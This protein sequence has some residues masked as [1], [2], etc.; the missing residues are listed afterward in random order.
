MK[1]AN[2]TVSAPA[3]RPRPYPPGM[4]PVPDAAGGTVTPE[5]LTR[6]PGAA[7][8]LA[9]HHRQSG[10]PWAWAAATAGA[11]FVAHQMPG[12]EAQLIAVAASAV[13][14][15]TAAAVNM[16]R[17]KRSGRV[18][19]VMAQIV[20]AD[21]VWTL[22]AALAGPASG[23]RFPPLL[24]AL[25]A[26]A[27]VSAWKWRKAAG[28]TV[29]AAPALPRPLVTPSQDPRLALFMARICK[30]GSPLHNARIDFALIDGGFLAD[31]ILDPDAP[32]T[33]D[34]VTRLALPIAKAFD[35]PLDQV[36]VED[37]PGRRSAGRARITVL[38][39]DAAMIEPEW[40]DGK[41][42]YDPE[43]GTVIIGRYMDGTPERWL[44][45]Q[46]GSGAVGGVDAGQQGYG[47]TT[48]A[49]VVMTESAKARL[50]TLCGPAHAC[51]RCRM[52]RFVCVW[53][54]DPTRKPFVQ[55]KGRADL[56]AWGPR[57][58]ILMTLWAV[59]A[60]KARTTVDTG[61]TDHRGRV[62]EGKGWYDPNPDMP[63][64]QLTVDEWP[65]IVTDPEGENATAA[66]SKLISL[67]RKYGVAVNLITLLPDL[68][69]MG[70]RDIRELLL[71]YNVL[72]H[73]SDSLSS[74]TL[75]IQGNPA[76]LPVNVPGLNFMAGVDGR[77][78]VVARVK[79]LREVLKPGETGVD[80]RDLWDRIALDPVDLESS[81]M[82]VLRPL[83][84]TG[85]G[86]VLKDED[87]T[88]GMWNAALVAA[89]FATA[90]PVSPTTAQAVKALGEIAAPQGGAV[91]LKEASA[92]RRAIEAAALDGRTAD[93]FDVIRGTEMS[94]LAGRNAANALVAVGDAV[95][96]GDGK[97]TVPSR[98]DAR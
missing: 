19:R 48:T 94:V 21:A 87:I 72:C 30:P 45:H 97:Y 53:A 75:G 49:L 22:T 63:L 78:A 79:G 15:A 12:V 40:W 47:K 34:D 24:I 81:M 67:G 65:Q 51:K 89:G 1:H 57:A 20:A 10:A 88:D 35:I 69:F 18:R 55:L 39:E 85:R 28:K 86:Q 66:A 14:T 7:R 95:K 61:W 74:R 9:A 77:S 25:A 5:A 43:T 27:A 56:V 42:T 23:G 41:P 91:G 17:R 13:V 71:A 64:L 90:A 62:H 98:D 52:E 44:I 92:A 16:K 46:P 26:G 29:P 73:R 33:T 84:Y 50:C 80:A 6:R 32:H 31:V 76:A 54:G 93:E 11:G 59:A 68:P 37:H 60:M 3:D 58:V 4:P 83:G 38:T 36:T 82:A 96:T 70:P 2:P 8:S